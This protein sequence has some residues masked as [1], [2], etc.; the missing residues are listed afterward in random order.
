MRTTLAC[1]AAASF[2]LLSNVVSP[3]EAQ[4]RCTRPHFTPVEATAC[5]KG[6]EGVTELRRYV[7]RTQMIHN[8]YLPHYVPQTPPAATA[9]T[10]DKEA[11]KAER[12]D[13][14]LSR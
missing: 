7:W 2:A 10:Q 11:P 14:A 8:L 3:A 9:R 13:V 6:K 12:D 1:A 5:A 4:T